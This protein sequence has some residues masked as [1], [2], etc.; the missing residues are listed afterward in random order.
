M[1]GADVDGTMADRMDALRDAAE[2]GDAAAQLELANRHFFGDGVGHDEAEACRWMRKAAEAGLGEAIVGIG[3]LFR[4]GVAGPEDLAAAE[5]RALAF[6]RD[7]DLDSLWLFFEVRRE[8]APEPPPPPGLDDVVAE[9]DR[10]QAN[11]RETEPPAADAFREGVDRYWGR[12]GTRDV[13]GALALLESAAGSGNADAARFLALAYDG[14]GEGVPQ[15]HET[16]MRWYE[17]AARLGDAH[18]CFVVGVELF[19]GETP[20]GWPRGLELIERAAERGFPPACGYLGGYLA[21]QED[22]RG[23]LLEERAVPLLRLGA[24]R[25]DPDA[26]RTLAGLLEDSGGPERQEAAYWLYRHARRDAASARMLGLAYGRGLGVEKSVKAATGWL[27]LA[28]EGGDAEAAAH[29]AYRF[30]HGSGVPRDP[31]LAAVFAERAADARIGLGARLLG[32]IHTD[33]LG[34]PRSDERAAEWY[35][36]GAALGDAFSMAC[37][38]S[39]LFDGR[40]CDP[41]P[42]AAVE[43]LRKATTEGPDG[44]HLLAVMLFRGEGVSPDPAEARRLFVLS[45][46]DGHLPSRFTTIEE[47]A[48][49]FRPA[50]TRPEKMTERIE[51]AADELE[52]LAA[53]AALDA[54]VLVWN[55]DVSLLA[56]DA[57]AARFFRAAAEKGDALAAACLSHVLGRAGDLEGEREW[58]ER[59]SRAG[60][61]GA[62]RHLAV[63][64]VETGPAGRDDP[65]VVALLESAADG[66]DAIA[67]AELAR[68]LERTGAA[69]DARGAERVAAL[70]RCAAASGYPEEEE[71]DW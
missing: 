20:E 54:G 30:L 35:G 60:L 18:S 44:R 41:D 45:A 69:D 61:L 68:H 33:G 24:V 6:H 58:L 26:A 52:M 16:A 11:R 9:L 70:R 5:E 59:A 7:G 37:F 47:E 28:A 34:V 64:L 43:W 71:P 56:D 10:R 62:Q 4:K 19:D 14:Y 25:G 12:G 17:E 67:C 55:G 23:D 48:L 42:A 32:E 57:L 53:R 40:G 38:A 46:A 39:M 63:R 49:R 3:R 27:A 29:L 8:A 21:R 2:A 65:P 22:P 15:S 66:G 1:T 51:Q 13:A 50:G 31:L 36:R